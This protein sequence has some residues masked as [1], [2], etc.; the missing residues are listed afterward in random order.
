MID[1]RKDIRGRGSDRMEAA[2]NFGAG[3]HVGA[4]PGQPSLLS[5]LAARK[6]R[7]HG[8]AGLP[9]SRGAKVLSPAFSCL[10]HQWT[11]MIKA[12]EDTQSLN[13]CVA[14]HISLQSIVLEHPSR[15]QDL[16]EAPDRP[17]RKNI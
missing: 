17:R 9:T 6:V 12:G 13:G 11:V 14:V 16:D 7:F 15:L 10:G 3:V 4:Q 2:V 5:D 1:P 8:F